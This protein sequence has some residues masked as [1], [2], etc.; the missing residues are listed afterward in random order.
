MYRCIFSS[1]NFT[2]R[3]KWPTCFP[4]EHINRRPRS[5]ST[6]WSAHSR[7]D[8]H[9][10][11]W[12][13]WKHRWRRGRRL[14]LN[15]R[16]I[17]TIQCNTQGKVITVWWFL[18]NKQKKT[19]NKKKQPPPPLV[20]PDSPIFSSFHPKQSVRE[21]MISS[22][23]PI[24][25]LPHYVQPKSWSAPAEKVRRKS[26]REGKGKREVRKRKSEQT[27][28]TDLFLSSGRWASFLPGRNQLKMPPP[29]PW[30]KRRSGYEYS[31]MKLIKA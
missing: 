3:C 11:H 23:F 31:F 2:R 20:H 1:W 12:S 15:T 7:S 26:E 29:L 19:K 25:T 8:P 18:K 27:T 22:L 5:Q 4:G 28:L 21:M 30:E 14:A 16:D 13:F 10:A 24:T 6:G 17:P 9:V